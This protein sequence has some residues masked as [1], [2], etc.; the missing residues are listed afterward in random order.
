MKGKEMSDL[1]EKLVPVLTK[2]IRNCQP[3]ELDKIKQIQG[4]RE[5]VNFAAFLISVTPEPR[6]KNYLS[7]YRKVTLLIEESEPVQEKLF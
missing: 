6:I 1:L 3:S 2:S 7:T 4:M 5:A